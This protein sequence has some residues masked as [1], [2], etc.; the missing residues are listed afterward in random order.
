[1]TDDRK[2]RGERRL[3]TLVPAL[4][5]RHVGLQESSEGLE[6]GGQQERHVKNA[7]ALGEAL[8]DTLFLG[9]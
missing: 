3:Q 7:G 4:R 2:D 6:L 1:V 8:A 5:H 9:V